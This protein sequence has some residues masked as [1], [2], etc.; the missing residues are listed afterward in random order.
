MNFALPHQLAEVVVERWHTYVS[1]QDLKAPPIP[2]LSELRELLTIIFFASMETEEGRP[3]TFCLCYSETETIRREYSTEQVPVIPFAKPRSLT[4]DSLRS[5][6]P[7][8]NRRNSALIVGGASCFDEP[9]DLRISGLLHVGSDLANARSGKTHFYRRPPYVLLVDV[10]GPGNLHVYQGSIKIAL[11]R[12]GRIEDQAIVSHLDLVGANE[13]LRRGEAVL[14]PRITPPKCEPAREWGPFQFSALLNTLLCIVN[15]IAELRHGGALLIVPPVLPSESESESDPETET[16]FALPLRLKYALNPAS[17]FLDEAFVAFMNARH[18]WGDVMDQAEA[19]KRRANSKEPSVALE[20][21]VAD[22]EL[23]DRIDTVARLSGV[24]GAVVLTSSLQL[25]GF[26]A[27]ILLESA[28]PITVLQVTGDA[29]RNRQW[30]EQDS[31]AFGMRHRSAVRFVGAVEGAVA[32]IVSQDGVISFCWKDQGRT[33]LK[34]NI[35]CTNP[36][37]AGG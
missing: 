29:L 23:A 20:T 25:L 19:G 28:P 35:N 6:A 18:R 16:G 7:A 17:P 5:L 24:D 22:S 13:L 15:G 26:G 10:R 12:S 1:R 3:L 11:L 37:I 21:R 14:M 27:E 33:L 30:P 32:F 8:A 34:R 2:S 36:N 9:T 31:E 4:V